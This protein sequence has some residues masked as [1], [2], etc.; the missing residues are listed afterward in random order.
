MGKKKM[1][2]LLILFACMSPLGFYMG[3]KI[4]ILNNYNEEIMAIVVGVFLYISTTILFESSDH[5]KLNL[6]KIIVII[7]AIG[8]VLITSH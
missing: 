3:N 8:I 5:H 7:S 2:S 1:I 6:Q 4:E